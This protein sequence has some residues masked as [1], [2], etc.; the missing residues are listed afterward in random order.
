MGGDR[1][2]GL[3]KS[4]DRRQPDRPAAVAPSGRVL[5]REPQH[6]V[7]DVLAPIDA[8]VQR[9]KVIGEYR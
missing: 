7:A 6:Q 2:G 3:Q 4:W 1:P 5:A 8:P 9:G